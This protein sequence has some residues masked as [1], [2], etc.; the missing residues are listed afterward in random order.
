MFS[1]I[2]TLVIAAISVWWGFKFAGSQNFFRNFENN[3]FID[4]WNALA[5]DE[6]YSLTFVGIA[7]IVFLFLGSWL[8][9]KIFR[10][11]RSLLQEIETLT[12]TSSTFESII[13]Q[14]HRTRPSIGGKVLNFSHEEGYA[15]VQ[16]N[17][18]LFPQKFFSHPLLSVGQA[19][20]ISLGLFG[21]F[22]GLSLGLLEAI[23]CFDVSSPEYSTCFP[24]DTPPVDQDIRAMTFGMN[25]LLGG[26]RTAFSKSLTGL[27]LGTSYLILWKYYL[28]EQ[29]QLLKALGTKL[30]E[31]VPFKSLEQFLL[32][33][34]LQHNQMAKRYYA[35][36]RTVAEANIHYLKTLVEKQLDAE[37]FKIAG[38]S[39]V[40]GAQELKSVASSLG[41]MSTSLQ[42]S[43]SNLEN[44]R[45]DTIALEVS[46]GVG[47]AVQQHLEPVLQGMRQEL[48]IIK[49]IKLQTDKQITERLEFLVGTLQKEALQPMAVQL[50]QTNQQTT[51]VAGVISELSA[52][53]E[54]TL[55][56]T[57][58]AANTMSGLTETLMDFNQKT[59]SGLQQ[60]AGDLNATL[61]KFSKESSREFK[62]M[63]TSIE[64]SVQTAIQGMEA[65][66]IA[67][68]QS[69]KETKDA[70]KG[71]TVEVTNLVQ[72]SREGIEEQKDAFVEA[73]SSA[74][75]TFESQRTL[76]VQ[77]GEE[78]STQIRNAGQQAHDSLVLVKDTFADTLA[79]QTASLEHI[80]ESLETAF[81]QDLEQRQ[82]FTKEISVS[83]QRI[84][85][86]VKLT[87][88]DDVTTRQ[89]ALEVTREQ[90]KSLTK[91]ER[92]LNDQHRSMQEFVNHMTNQFDKLQD[93]HLDIY[94][95]ST[96]FL[97]DGVTD[98]QRTLNDVGKLLQLIA[99]I[100]NRLQLRTSR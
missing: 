82:Q 93:T 64:L 78:T 42:D 80:L 83:I 57:Q 29:Q 9:L 10:D 90:T 8:C 25:K 34:Q 44:F 32:E 28:R 61:Q 4:S 15:F 59:M 31:M 45:A 43:L 79:S 73:A 56:A 21:T 67:F 48:E 69:A 1:L 68:S 98:L 71:M 50:E 12:D 97:S 11:N 37:T 18:N 6:M 49:D 19:L 76:I 46:K 81:S 86:L 53:V 70:F 95:E 72:R 16:R 87:A 51:R 65:Q 13:R 52:G 94:K 38:S 77:A 39:L 17:L 75:Q 91:L 26:A 62:A 85:T 27:G 40:A 3:S 63:G 14:F 88:L 54:N 47:T 7:T 36:E 2:I 89:N 55:Q 24:S 100:T 41:A 33:H 66:R 58:A 84:E 23:P 22:F 92:S 99:D 5:V 96:Q 20:L 74:T 60:F 35:Q 30:N